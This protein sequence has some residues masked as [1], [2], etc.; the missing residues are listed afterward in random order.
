MHN[1]TGNQTNTI[2][3]P[4]EVDL[5]QVAFAPFMSEGKIQVFSS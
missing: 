2:Y 3:A 1:T 4:K 5:T